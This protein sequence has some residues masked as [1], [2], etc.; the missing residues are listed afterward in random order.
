MTLR[1]PTEN[2]NGD[3]V[4]PAWIAGI[5]I[6]KEAFG[7]IHVNLDSSSSCWNDELRALLEVIEVLPAVFSKEPG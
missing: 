4:M 3:F 6:R 1:S 7:D 2:E 5:Q